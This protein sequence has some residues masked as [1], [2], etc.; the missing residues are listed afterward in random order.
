MQAPTLAQLEAVSDIVYAHMQGSPLLRWPLLSE[1]CG[2]DVQVKHENHNPT[3][4]FKI[5][6]G[7]NLMGGKNLPSRS[8]VVGI[9]DEVDLYAAEAGG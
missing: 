9:V 7:I 4:T 1:R 2:C 5:R 6:G 3:G 8:A